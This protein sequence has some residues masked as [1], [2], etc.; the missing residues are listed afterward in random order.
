MI[1]NV[2]MRTTSNQLQE[3]MKEDI[4]KIQQIPEVIVQADKTSNL[5]LIKKD[6]YCKY[7]TESISKEYKKTE[8]ATLN[9]INIEAAKTARTFNLD[10]RIEAIAKKP[11][12][13]TLKDHKTDFPARLNFRLINPCKSNIGKISKSIL[14]RINNE[15]KATTGLNQW[16]STG[17]VLD[18]FRSLER[19][20]N[21]KWLKFDIESFYPSISMDLLN[22][23][24]T[25]VKGITYI[26]SEEEDIILH[27]RKTVLIGEGESIW[28][29]KNNPDFDVPMGS[30][31]AAE[32]SETVGLYLL[33]RMKEI[34]PEGRGGLYRDDGL[35]VVHGNGQDV[36]RI[37]KKLIKL[38][39]EEGLKITSECNTTVV[40]YLD[41]IMDL[42]NNSYKPFIKPNANTKYVS[43][44]SNHPPSILANIPDAISRRL[45]SVSSSKEM[46]DSEVP[47]YQQALLDAGYKD[48]L[49]Y[50]EDA[51]LP[52]ENKRRS[53]AAIW[54]NP[55]FA[56]NVKSNIGKRFLQLLRK[57]FPPSSD[58][59]KLF[60]CKKVKLSY[61][62]CPSMK[63][64]ISSHNAKVIKQKKLEP[65][66]GCNCRGG[67]AS[68]PLG[69]RCLIG[70]LVYKASV[71]T[72]QGE[73]SYLGQAASSFKLRFN[74]HKSSFKND[75]TSHS[76]ALSTYVS[77][78]RRREVDYTI[79]WSIES[80]P[81]PYKGGGGSCHL[82]LVEKTL[83]A[84]SDR[85]VSLNR[86]TEIMTK[87]RHKMPF[88]LDN[89]HGIHVPPDTQPQHV[90]VQ[91]E[92]ISHEPAPLPLPNPLPDPLPEPLPDPLPDHELEAMPAQTEVPTASNILLCG[93]V[94]RSKARK[95]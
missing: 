94:T 61:S 28:I 65:M 93:P 13:L 24:L 11:A 86:R 84:R 30:L 54:F 44:L 58:L 32:V 36:E 14:D 39:H 38:F 1:R 37:R 25:Y 64:I 91:A 35:V 76:T 60:N 33:W 68:C 55:P 71:T 46:F 85:R 81:E 18:W 57:H 19:K 74:N 21:L 77:G 6:I 48:D 66:R 90:P 29:K 12:Y 9:K 40:D 52:G 82:C 80:T 50:R 4:K 16:K 53:R 15:V 83:I 87:C 73:R 70:C 10:D 43:I 7:L 5:Y 75:A 78:L 20:K 89:F 42:Q 26:T 67:V 79:R 72:A 62:C 31:D 2:E 47:H 95:K 59:Y 56:S 92:H 27:C 22:K 17:E 69:G 45:S 63:T 49:L 3:R 34:I 51:Q 88:Y 8:S 41:V 23:A